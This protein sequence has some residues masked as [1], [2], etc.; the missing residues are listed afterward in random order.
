MQN[1]QNSKVSIGSNINTIRGI[2]EQ[3]IINF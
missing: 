1:L 3:A 2:Q